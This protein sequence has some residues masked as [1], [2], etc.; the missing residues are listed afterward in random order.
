[1]A[2]MDANLLRSPVRHTSIDVTAVDE[3][4]VLGNQLGIEGKEVLSC[5]LILHALVVGLDVESL[6]VQADARWFESMS[7]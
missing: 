4:A 1:M 3:N 7:K 2:A 5:L 6:E